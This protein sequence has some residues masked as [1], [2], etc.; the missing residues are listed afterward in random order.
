MPECGMGI[1]GVACCGLRGPG[2]RVLMEEGAEDAEQ[3]QC[4]GD[5]NERLLRS[6]SLHTAPT[7]FWGNPSKVSI[8]TR[9]ET[10]NPSS[11]CA[12][13]LPIRGEGEFAPHGR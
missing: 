13:L 10:R 12:I 7:P 8:G 11:D 1:R 4:R 5:K 6:G 2:W 9:A 3:T